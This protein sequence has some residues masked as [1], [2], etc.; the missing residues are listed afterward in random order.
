[1]KDASA[2]HQLMLE[3]Y[4][5]GELS[6]PEM[7]ALR[8]ALAADPALRE[9]LAAIERSDHDILSSAPPAQFAD[10]VEQRIRRQAAQDRGRG[11]RWSTL[12]PVWALSLALIV[13]SALLLRSG[14]PGAAGLSPATS[15]DRSKG[16]APS[17]LLFRKNVD[18]AIERLEPGAVAHDRDVVQVAYQASGRRYGVIL[19]IDG[20]GAVT[21]HLPASG[22]EAAPLQPSG[23]ALL[24]VAYRLDDAPRL[25]RFYFVASDQPFAVS[26]VEAAARSAASDPLNADRLPL[27]PPL[28]Q[29]S[30]LLRK[31]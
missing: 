9:R 23:P 19:S 4:R 11:P 21:R 13:T 26:P 28:T 8:E 5:L 18:S 29:A 10:S 31:E 1:M 12:A 3:R 30:F 2:V 27:D 20:R 7:D 25:E 15:G 22:D 17:L 6:Q 14:L 16:G 24:Q